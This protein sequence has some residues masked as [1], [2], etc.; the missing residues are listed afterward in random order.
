MSLSQLSDVQST[1]GSGG[2][3][4]AAQAI[5]SGLANNLNGG[6]QAAAT[7]G[8]GEADTRPNACS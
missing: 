7:Q 6:Q 8:T 2:F 1:G 5:L 3:G 4:S